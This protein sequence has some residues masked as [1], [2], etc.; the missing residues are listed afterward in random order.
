MS[1]K[2]RYGYH[3][4]VWGGFALTSFA[5]NGC[6]G[7]RALTQYDTPSSPT[8]AYALSGGKITRFIPRPAS[9]SDPRDKFL[10]AAFGKAHLPGHTARS[11]ILQ[12]PGN[13]GNCTIGALAVGKHTLVSVEDMVQMAFGVMVGDTP[14]GAWITVK[15]KPFNG[16]PFLETKSGE[17]FVYPDSQVYV[18]LTP[19]SRWAVVGGQRI[20]LKHPVVWG[21]IKSGIE[22]NH[23]ML[24]EDMLRVFQQRLGGPQA[25]HTRVKVLPNPWSVR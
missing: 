8:D 15:G 16:K 1:R 11:V 9:D 12:L 14:K 4:L 7:R 18:Q 17:L 3:V 6:E 21:D 23:V 5:L 2:I 24:L 22:G 19:G 10:L 25:I 13:R 20:A